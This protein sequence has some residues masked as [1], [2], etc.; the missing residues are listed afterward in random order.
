MSLNWISSLFFSRSTRCHNRSL[1]LFVRARRMHDVRKDQSSISFE[2]GSYHSSTTCLIPACVIENKREDAD[3]L[4]PS[5]ACQ[6]RSTYL[7]IERQFC[8][9][10]F[11][12]STYFACALPDSIL[13]DKVNTTRKGKWWEKWDT[14]IHLNIGMKRK[15]GKN[16]VVPFVVVGCIKVK[17]PTD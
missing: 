3:P 13:E 9:H 6:G 11:S 12:W 17:Q 15:K 4:H 16:R 7:F 1:D 8:S 14:H 10:P 2:C 5:Q